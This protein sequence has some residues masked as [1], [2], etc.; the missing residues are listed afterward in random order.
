MIWILNIGTGTYLYS[1]TVLNIVLY[2]TSIY[3]MYSDQLV[4]LM[5]IIILFSS[6]VIDNLLLL[7]GYRVQGCYQPDDQD[8]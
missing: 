1:N 4:K 5:E 8:Q 7:Q 2:S 6:F 3:S